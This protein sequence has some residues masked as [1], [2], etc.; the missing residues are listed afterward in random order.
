MKIFIT[1]CF[2]FFSAQLLA[3]ESLET[4]EDKGVLL[5][6]NAS[7]KVAFKNS[8]NR[9]TDVLLVKYKKTKSLIKGSYFYMFNI[10]DTKK[11][12]MCQYPDTIKLSKELLENITKLTK[13]KNNVY[14]GT[15]KNGD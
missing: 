10:L 8:G 7:S 2:L 4:K 5:I 3:N 11:N 12:V 1:I 15:D 6:C 14:R 13:I 9:Q